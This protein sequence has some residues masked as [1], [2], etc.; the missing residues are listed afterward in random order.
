VDS[1]AVRATTSA[2]ASP[3]VLDLPS[4]NASLRLVRDALRAFAR[5]ADVGLAAREI[6]EVEVA[7]H[8][9][10]T[11]AIRHAHG[12]DPSKC[13]RV[14]MRR[15]SDALEILVRDHGA[16][17]DL[18]A[19]AARTPEDLHEGG[20]G[21]SIIKSWTDEATVSR[22][23]GGNVLRLVRRRRPPSECVDV[24]GR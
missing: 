15:R 10:C 18:D 4:E 8:E 7:V 12:G 22:E 14:E 2:S 23:D 6:G 19:S 5:D 3:L 1:P 24:G 11:N 21:L 13:F 9:A 20:Y 17:F 16:P